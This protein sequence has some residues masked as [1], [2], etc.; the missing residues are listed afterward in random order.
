MVDGC[1]GRTTLGALPAA[2]RAHAP[3]GAFACGARRRLP[4]LARPRRTQWEF[5]A[6]SMETVWAS[7]W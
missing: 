2:L 5:V 4:S 7:G 1:R 6:G 3:A